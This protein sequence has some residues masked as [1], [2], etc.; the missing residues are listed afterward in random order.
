M[1]IPP[2]DIGGAPDTGADTGGAPDTGTPDTGKSGGDAVSQ[3]QGLIQVGGDSADG[4]DADPPPDSEWFQGLPPELQEAEPINRLRSKSM[5]EFARQYQEVHRFSGGKAGL[6]MPDDK[7]PD[8]WGKTLKT[9]GAP[10]SADAYKYEA[11]ADLRFTELK[12]NPNEVAL[13]GLMQ[14]SGVLPKQAETLLPGILKL[15]DSLIGDALDARNERIAADTA[16]LKQEWG[17]EYDANQQLINEAFQEDPDAAQAIVDAGLASHPA[18][19]RL[20]LKYAKASQDDTS[21]AGSASN[22]T[23]QQQRAQAQLDEMDKNPE[24]LKAMM[25]SNHPLHRELKAEAARLQRIIAGEED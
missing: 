4:V 19:A 14:E 12:D 16:V 21:A 23:T 2:N 24:K 5:E 17:A 13:R 6:P 7:D 25:D 1:V 11:P 22:Y 8:S 20:M 15:H 10:E 9:L 18:L 3:T